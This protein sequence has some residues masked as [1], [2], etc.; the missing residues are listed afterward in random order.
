MKGPG[1]R[2]IHDARYLTVT[3]FVSDHAPKCER[4][5]EDSTR[6]PAFLEHRDICLHHE[7]DQVLEP[8][9]GLPAQHSLRLRCIATEV[10]HLGR[11]VALLVRD[12]KS[13]RLNRSHGST[14]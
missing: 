1:P 13:T 6:L 3:T 2:G 14:S 10:V 11:A 7:A 8:R 9:L 5:A 4:R 12:R